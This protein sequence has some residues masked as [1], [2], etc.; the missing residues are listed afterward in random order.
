MVQDWTV[1]L[2]VDGTPT[3]VSGEL[4]L[5]AGVSP[6]PWIALASPA[7]PWSSCSAAAARSCPPWR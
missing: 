2:T 4:V 6:L 5:A 7:P 3:D 1:A